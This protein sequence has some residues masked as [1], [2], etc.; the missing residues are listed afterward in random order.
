M[1]QWHICICPNDISFWGNYQVWQ[2]LVA[3]L[4]LLIIA[5]PGHQPVL[6]C[7]VPQV[8]GKRRGWRLSVYVSLLNTVET[9]KSPLATSDNSSTLVRDGGIVIRRFC[10]TV[11]IVFDLVHF[12]DKLYFYLTAVMWIVHLVLWLPVRHCPYKFVML[13]Q[14][15][16]LAWPCRRNLDIVEPYDDPL[17][18]TW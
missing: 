17:L 15:N 12:Q 2:V 8:F 6:F 7:L 4:K 16:G 3:R 9:L 5:L 11:H 14:H 10:L 18:F 13:A 1:S